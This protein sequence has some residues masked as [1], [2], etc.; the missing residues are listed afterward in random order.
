M[1]SQDRDE[2]YVTIAT[3]DD[4][5]ETFLVKR[6]SQMS[7]RG[8]TTA[9]D[10]TGASTL[11]PAVAKYGSSSLRYRRS[12]GSGSPTRRVP[13]AASL[14]KSM[15]SLSLGRFEEESDSSEG[16]DVE[17][18]D[19]QIIR[20][21]PFPLLSKGGP[22]GGNI[23]SGKTD[24]TSDPF[25]GEDKS[26]TGDDEEEEDDGSDAKDGHGSGLAK[27][28]LRIKPVKGF[29]KIVSFGP[30]HVD[31][32]SHMV[33]FCKMTACLTKAVLDPTDHA[34]GKGSQK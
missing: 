22:R 12:Q 30:F 14:T 8:S 18:S 7:P 5:Y 33:E 31:V 16:S 10:G 2:I 4:E 28:R 25:W 23:P 19:E 6:R 20:K 24:T 17:D 1:I 15:N 26:E 13:G 21:T 9:G 11:R 29:L 34:K 3:Y 27:K 32:P